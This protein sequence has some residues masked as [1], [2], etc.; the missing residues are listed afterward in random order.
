M[1][2]NTSNKP[3]KPKSL[4]SIIRGKNCSSDNN[5]SKLD[6]KGGSK[7]KKSKD[8]KQKSSSGIGQNKSQYQVKDSTESDSIESTDVFSVDIN[9]NQ[10]IYPCKDVVLYTRVILLPHHI[11]NDLYI[12]LKKNLIDKVEGKCIKDGYVIKIYKILEYKDGIIE[13][14][15]FTGSAIYDVKY[16][17]KICVALKESTIVAKITSYIPNANLL[18]AEFGTIMKIILAKNKRDLNEKNFIIGNDKSI[19]HKPTQRKIGLND[20]VKIQL[21]SIK[22]HHNDIVIK[23]MGYLDDIAYPEDIAEFA[24]K[25]DNGQKIQK[26][27]ESNK[28]IYFNED[29]EQE[30]KNIENSIVNNSVDIIELNNKDGKSRNNKMDI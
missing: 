15:N 8:I 11:N 23:C 24:F 7:V 12:N 21:K 10:L 28:T 2:S 22:F 3:N 30:D 9:L 26:Q 19:L 1:N 18:L 6:L 20:F 16:L 17:A 29:N 27:N 5:E 14:E 13:P 4:N 25:E